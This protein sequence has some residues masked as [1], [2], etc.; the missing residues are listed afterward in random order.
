MFTKY[1]MVDFLRATNINA[2]EPNECTFGEAKAKARV[3]DSS[4]TIT[5]YACRLREVTQGPQTQ[6]FQIVKVISD[7]HDSQIG[8]TGGALEDVEK[9]EFLCHIVILSLQKV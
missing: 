4:Q 6:H 3:S 5:F 8:I 2:F 9:T 7:V 1:A